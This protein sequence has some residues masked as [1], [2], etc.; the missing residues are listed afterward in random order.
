MAKDVSVQLWYRLL[1]LGAVILAFGVL[2]RIVDSR[3]LAKSLAPGA[4]TRYRV[5]RRTLIATIVGF[6]VFS[7]LLVIPQVRAVAGG[8]LAS[9]AVVGLIVGF[10]ARTTLANFVAG[11]VIAITQPLRLGDRVTVGAGGPDGGS[12]GVV[13]EIRL[14]YTFIRTAKG[15]RLVVP[16]ERL[17]TEVI[18]NSTIVS[19]A[20]LA[21]ATVDVPVATDV[22]R[23]LAA[24]RSDLEA[25]LG[26]DVEVA[27]SAVTDRA[28]LAVRAWAKDEVEALELADEL[29]LRAH[30]ALRAHGAYPPGPSPAG[31]VE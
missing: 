18:R 26:R 25:A 24:L 31:A 21:E 28:T 15:D 6:G 16:N 11:L 12:E 27:L 4:E 8:L 29:R 3:M 17:A 7:A 1:I 19:R 23:L 30:S 9:S 10:A 14:T 22:D 5:L 20:K 13:E 2:A